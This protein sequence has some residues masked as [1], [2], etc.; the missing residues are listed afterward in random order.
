MFHPNVAANLSSFHYRLYAFSF[1]FL[2]K[3]CQQSARRSKP[4][5]QCRCLHQRQTKRSR[6]TCSSY[7]P[8]IHSLF[9][10][11]FVIN[12]VRRVNAFTWYWI[13]SRHFRFSLKNYVFFGDVHKI[14][15]HLLSECSKYVPSSHSPTGAA[16]F[17]KQSLWAVITPELKV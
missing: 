16:F 4:L 11:Y 15:I 9:R 17:R 6:W 5:C 2:V 7:F 12:P 10:I 14:S 3:I 8:A 13:R 1:N